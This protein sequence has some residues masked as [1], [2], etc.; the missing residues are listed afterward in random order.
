MGAKASMRAWTVGLLALFII[1][2]IGCEMPEI[3][4]AKGPRMAGLDIGQLV[5]IH[6]SRLVLHGLR[7]QV[8]AKDIFQASIRVPGT[9][10]VAVYEFAPL[11]PYGKGDLVDTWELPPEKTASAWDP[12]LYGYNIY[13]K[14]RDER[15]KGPRVT[16]EVTFTTLERETFQ[17]VSFG[18][19]ISG[20]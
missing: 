7:L 20:E 4:P 9:I 2:I 11:E 13:L 6:N 12:G 18:I 19:S 5:P 10:K 16:V 15:P 8:Y 14:W 3:T 17:A 1:G